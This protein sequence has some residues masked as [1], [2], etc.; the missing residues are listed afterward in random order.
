MPMMKRYWAK[1][2]LTSI[3]YEE[4]GSSFSARFLIH[5]CLKNKPRQF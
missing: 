5:A 3:L 1:N 4:K 2:Q